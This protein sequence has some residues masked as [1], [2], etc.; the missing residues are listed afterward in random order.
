MAAPGFGKDMFS[1]IKAELP[2]QLPAY[3]KNQRWFGAKAREISATDVIDVI[4]LQREGLDAVVL[5]VNVEYQGGGADLYSVPLVAGDRASSPDALWISR[6]DAG[7]KVTFG[8]A[9]Q[10]ESFL[11]L[12]LEAI[13]RGLIFTGEVGELRTSCT[14]ALELQETGA[15][16]S[17]LPRAIKAEQSNSSI[18]YGERLMLKFFRRLEEGINPDLEMSGFLTEKAGYQHTPQLLGALE[19]RAANGRL[20]TQAILQAFVANQGDAWQY[21]MKSISSFYDEVG[22]IAISGALTAAQ[23]NSARALMAPFLDSVAL[24]ARRTAE[25]HLALASAPAAQHPDFS[26]EP[27]DA[28]FQEGFEQA[29]EELTH[30]VFKQLRKANEHFPDAVKAK[31]VEL[32]AAEGDIRRRFHTALSDPVRALRTRIH[33]DYHLGQVL[34]TGSD[35]VIIDFEGEPARPM[36]QR[37]LKRSPLQ[38]VAAMLRSFH[39][40]AYAR[41]LAATGTVQFDDRNRQNLNA[42]A[43]RWAK[44]VGDRFLEEYLKV[45]HGAAFLPP[46]RAEIMALLQLQLLEKAVYELGYELN[47]RPDWVAIPLEGISKTLA[48]T[49]S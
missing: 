8:D 43:E 4:R 34:Y 27:F 22:S 35:F 45:A 10:E 16:G 26:P 41:L 9:M 39:Y 2:S 36:S 11:S 30:R 5:L 20:M 32:L 3:L 28:N 47:N 15:A 7:R 48:S 14:H 25:L 44:W 42:W 46:T 24:L 19:Y 33:G 49:I 40:A 21:T 12:L 31:A 13:Q 1:N 37:R 38:D 6:G 18:A 23:E 17:L 29:L